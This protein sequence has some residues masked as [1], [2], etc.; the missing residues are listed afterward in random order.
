MRAFVPKQPPSHRSVPGGA[1]RSGATLSGAEHDTHS[2]L[3]LQRAIGNRAV[4]RLLQRDERAGTAR[5]EVIARDEVPGTPEATTEKPPSPEE[6]E[7]QARN[8]YPNNPHAAALRKKMIL[9]TITPAELSE[10]R[11]IA[12]FPDNPRAAL[13]YAKQD[14][15]TITPAEQEELRGHFSRRQAQQRDVEDRLLSLDPGREN[16][17]AAALRAKQ[18]AGG[19]SREEEAEL[20]GLNG[21]PDNPRAAALAAKR[22]LGTITRD[23]QAELQGFDTYPYNRRAAMLLGRQLR[24]EKLT[25]DEEYEMHE[26]SYYQA[27][28]EFYIRLERKHREGRL[29]ER[30]NGYLSQEYETFERLRRDP[31]VLK[32]AHEI[33]SSGR[34][35]FSPFD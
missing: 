4:Q 2:L 21:Y 34:A 7:R 33:R 20:Q 22:I 35:V 19:L 12:S 14:A 3:H 10:L 23:E 13:L 25:R 32:R 8:A 1:L 28:G 5:G 27:M 30:E 11:G 17:R 29:K 24:G 18:A 31:R 15:G 16:P 9:G 6:A 26:E